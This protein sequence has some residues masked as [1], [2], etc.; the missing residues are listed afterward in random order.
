MKKLIAILLSMSMCASFALTSCDEKDE[1]KDKDKD[2]EVSAETEEQKDEDDGIKKKDDNTD[3]NDDTEEAAI[4]E[5]EVDA[6]PYE[7]FI[8]SISMGEVASISKLHVL[9]ETDGVEAELWAS[10][11]GYNES[12][13]FTIDVEDV[14]DAEIY[15]DAEEIVVKSD[16]IFD[17]NAYGIP[18][19]NI[20]EDFKNAEFWEFAGISYEEFCEQMVDELGF[21]M[22]K[23]LDEYS[24]VLG[25]S[26]TLSKEYEKKFLSI[27]NGAEHTVK[28]KDVEVNN[29]KV[30]A[31]V[32]D[33]TIDSSLI[34]ALGDLY[35]DLIKEV[36]MPDDV[37]YTT[38]EEMIDELVTMYDENVGDLNIT[39]YMN[40]LSA[41][42][43]KLTVN[44]T[45]VGGDE[46]SIDLDLGKDYTKSE[47][48]I[49]TVDPAGDGEWCVIEYKR[50]NTDSKFA[51]TATVK[52][53]YPDGKSE[54]DAKCEFVYNYDNG[55]YELKVDDTKMF[56]G[57]A[58]FSDSTVAGSF[59]MDDFWF[60][61]D[62]KYTETSIEADIESEAINF[63][64]VIDEE[65]VPKFPAYTNVFDMGE[66]AFEELFEAVEDSNFLGTVNDDYYYDYDD[67]YYDYDDYYYEDFYEEY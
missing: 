35:I 53:F 26:A 14:T 43:V 28:I 31:I 41:K 58:R 16:D 37:F 42:L 51:R 12:C 3:E 17:G 10:E 48:Y 11:E 40:V 7:A 5:E 21:D 47:K 56:W 64:V 6:A 44:V 22:I 15:V 57:T 59:E 23:W 36:P 46:L 39:A 27:L 65:E 62:V 30:A 25:N 13:A 19:D 20:I 9:F 54:V 50:E 38:Y 45:P 61:F 63:R 52:T 32:L 55:S 2:K 67:Y 33:Y 49:L 29:G 60:D 66:G 4:T 8:E 1:E 18:L 34:E 24:E